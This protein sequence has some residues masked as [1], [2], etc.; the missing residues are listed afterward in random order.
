MSQVISFNLFEYLSA[1]ETKARPLM[2]GQLEYV[3]AGSSS[4]QVSPGGE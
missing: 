2:I 3:G 1:V 4:G